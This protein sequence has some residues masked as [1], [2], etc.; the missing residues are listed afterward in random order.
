MPFS[1]GRSYDD[2][3]SAESDSSD[4]RPIDIVDKEPAGEVPAEPRSTRY[5]V[6]LAISCVVAI[7]LCLVG[8]GSKSFIHGSRIPMST[9]SEVQAAPAV[10]TQTGSEEQ[11]SVSE[12]AAAG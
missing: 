10:A 11:A 6:I 5:R 12:G 7:G 3:P 8:L 4:D 2:L 1:L 9:P